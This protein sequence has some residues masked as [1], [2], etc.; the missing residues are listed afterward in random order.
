L[1]DAGSKDKRYEHAVIST[2]LKGAPYQA[3]FSLLLERD[4]DKPE[5]GGDLSVES[6]DIEI[7]SPKGVRS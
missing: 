1:P 4:A 7:Q 6:L 3:T 2:I 5:L